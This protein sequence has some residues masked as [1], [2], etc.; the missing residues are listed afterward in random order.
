M[1]LCL[2]FGI[3]GGESCITNNKGKHKLN[4]TKALHQVCREKHSRRT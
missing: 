3:G 4:T 2:E 1:S